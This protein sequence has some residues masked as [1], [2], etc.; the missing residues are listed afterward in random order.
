MGPTISAAIQS[1]TGVAPTEIDVPYGSDGASLAQMQG[2]TVVW[3]TGDAYFSELSSDQT[4][5]TKETLTSTDRTNLTNFLNGGG[6]LV[7]TGKDALYGLQ[8]GT[9][10]S[11]FVGKSW[12]LMYFKTREPP[13]SL[14]RRERRSPQSRTT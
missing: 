4:A 14:G 11:G 6:K 1:A 12:V 7:I 3:T 2:K 5:I 9:F 10:L 13:R 8:Q